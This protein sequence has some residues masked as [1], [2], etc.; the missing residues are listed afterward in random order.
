MDTRRAV[1][2]IHRAQRII[3]RAMEDEQQERGARPILHRQDRNGACRAVTRVRST[4][5]IVARPLVD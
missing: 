3:A 5:P 4:T 2:D 1:M